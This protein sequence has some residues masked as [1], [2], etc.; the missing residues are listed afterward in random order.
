MYLGKHI[1]C[2]KDGTNDMGDDKPNVWWDG[3]VMWFDQP[4]LGLRIW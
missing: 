2:E 3:G 4:G 1:V